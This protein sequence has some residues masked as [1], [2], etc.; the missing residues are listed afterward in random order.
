MASS[1]RCV[2]DAGARARLGNLE[3]DGSRRPCTA[4]SA[5]GAERTVIDRSFLPMAAC[6]VAC[7]RPRLREDTMTLALKP[8]IKLLQ[9][10]SGPLALAL[11]LGSAAAQPSLRDN[12]L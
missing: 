2:S 9:I 4:H 3:M 8:A 6:G 12:L 10:A 1:R 7:E 5:E 11:S